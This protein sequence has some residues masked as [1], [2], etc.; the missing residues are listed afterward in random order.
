[1]YCR[2]PGVPTNGAPVGQ[3]SIRNIVARDRMLVDG[4]GR[5]ETI[6]WDQCHVGERRGG[7]ERRRIMTGLR[8]SSR[9]GGGVSQQTTDRTKV[10]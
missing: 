8:E 2:A 6:C 3:I 7:D 9:Q 1:M 5:V 10:R 4:D